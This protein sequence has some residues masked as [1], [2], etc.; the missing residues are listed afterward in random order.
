MEN[1]EKKPNNYLKFFAM[2]GTSMV[3]M[4]FLM[5]THSYQIIDHFWYSETRFFM[6]LIMGGS[7]VIIMLLYMLNMYKDKNKNIMILSLGVLLIAGGIWLVRSQVTVTGVDY[8]E[9][10]IPHHSI[11]ILTS[12]RSKIK[13]IRVRKIADEII[14]AQRREIMEMQWLI[15]DIKENG[16][17]ETEEE[18]EKR[19]LPKFEGSLIEETK[20]LND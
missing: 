19:P 7:M 16:I 2:I 6:T 8:M 20:N 15:N 14:K 11:A 3:A 5:Y 18:K 13:D 4:F 10:M 12:E 9:G 17:V 1:N